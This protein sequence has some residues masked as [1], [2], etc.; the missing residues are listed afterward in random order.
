MSEMTHR[1]RVTAAMNRQKPDRVPKE[2]S[3]TPAL[4][5]KFEEMTGQK[6]AH[7]YFDCDTAGVGF[8]GSG[9]VVDW[10]PWY[11]QGMPENTRYGEYGGAN[12][13]GSFYH[14][15]RYDFP[16]KTATTLKQIEEFPWPDF[17][18]KERHEHLEADVQRLHDDGWWVSGG[19]GH[20]WENAWQ[21]TSMEKLMLDF[22]E[23]PDQ[24]AF[25]LDKIMEDRKFQAV[26]YTQAGCDMILCGDD[27]GMQ[28]KLMMSPQ[29]WREWLKPRWKEVW[30]AAREVNPEVHIWYHSDGNIEEII[31][32]LIEIGMTI[33]N[34]VQPESMDPEKLKAQY[35]HQVA[36][37]GC[38]GTQ[39]V[40]PFGTPDEMR[41]TIKWLIETVGKDGGLL[42]APTHVL[43]PDV[44]WEN[45]V[46]FAEAV[47]EYGS[48][49]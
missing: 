38:V 30:A 31:P 34:P 16:L 9:K 26:R 7:E 37:W 17:T 20:I 24:A 23:H 40:F 8:K 44:P 19:V 12:I 35:G 15:N 48:Y 4:Q 14:F 11:P 36:F 32:D 45:I 46:A 33:L 10:S 27:V 18:P 42:L 29:M 2:L 6:N 41:K 22:I 43:E 49:G 47:A 28:H 1:E 21:V 3:L 25:V 5:A 13:P 39:T